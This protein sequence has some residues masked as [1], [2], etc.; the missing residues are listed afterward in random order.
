M[1]KPILLALGAIFLVVGYLIIKAGNAISSSIP[2][3]FPYVG[4]LGALIGSAGL[5]III[6]GIAIIVLVGILFL[7]PRPVQRG[8]VYK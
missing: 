4:S 5:W 8:I 7:L 2:A 6:L 3:W 1:N